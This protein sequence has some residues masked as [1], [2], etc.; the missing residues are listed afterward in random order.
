MTATQIGE[1]QTNSTLRATVV[2]SSEAIHVAKCAA[3]R[4]P[5]PVAYARARSEPLASTMPVTANGITTSSAS[6]TRQ[7]A[8]A[9]GGA[10]ARRAKIAPPETARSAMPSTTN[11]A[12]R[13]VSP[14]D[15]IACRLRRWPRP[16]PRASRA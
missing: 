12:A 7:A 10:S 2:Y 14:A 15:D 5:A 11:G 4:M 16:A 13:V 1:V 8:M 6:P 3:R 9:S